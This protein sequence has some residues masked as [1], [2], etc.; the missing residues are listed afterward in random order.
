[1]TVYHNRLS[2][3]WCWAEEGSE[4]E[5]VRLTD[6]VQSMGLT[7]KRVSIIIA[8][9]LLLSGTLAAAATVKETAGG[10]YRQGLSVLK[11]GA[12][13]KSVNLITKAIELTPAEYRYYNDRGVIY[14]R[15]GKLER[16]LEDYTK[17]LQIKPDYTN[18]LNNRGVVYIQQGHYARAIGDFD[19]A[20]LHGGLE[21]KILTNR[22]LAYLKQGNTERAVE[23]FRKAISYR[24]LDYRAFLYLGEALAKTGK[25]AK[26][27]KMYQL[28]VG[29]VKDRKTVRI[30]EQRI[31]KVDADRKAASQTSPKRKLKRAAPLPVSVTQPAGRLKQSETLPGPSR[32][33]SV[34]RSD[35]PKVPDA[36]LSAMTLSSLDK[37]SR[38]R[39]VDGFSRVSREI[40]QQGIKFRE[41]SEPRKAVV[42]FQDA[43]QLARREK[44]VQ[45]VAWCLLEIGRVHSATGEYFEALP[46]LKNAMKRFLKTK[47][48][49]EAILTLVELARASRA[50]GLK[51][52]APVFENRAR[53]MAQSAGYVAINGEIGSSPGTKPRAAHR[54]NRAK[55]PVDK[56]RKADISRTPS[57]KVAAPTPLSR[58]GRGPYLWGKRSTT[59]ASGEPKSPLP[60]PKAVPPKPKPV[61]ASAQQPGRVSFNIGGKQPATK[62]TTVEEQLLILKKLRKNSDEAGMIDVLE[63]LCELYEKGSDPANALHCVDAVIGFR[64]KLGRTDKMSR[65]LHKRGLLREKLG[66]QT[67]ALEDF[68][69]AAAYATAE[70]NIA[71]ADTS[72]ANAKS[73]A[74]KLGLNPENTLA[75]FQSLWN[76]RRNKQNHAETRALHSIAGVFRDSGKHQPAMNYLERT[77]ASLLLEKVDILTKMGKDQEAE[78][79]RTESLRTL[80]RLDYSRYLETLKRKDEPAIARRR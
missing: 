28:A 29:L 11:K 71:Q 32:Q 15:M 7:M 61:T 21:A 65:W 10:Y 22:G 30:L 35:K 47:S 2:I 26:A 17:A 56:A 50:A 20:L 60:R 46:Y 53:D 80:K 45:G 12:F 64:E 14:K 8:A 73:V 6:R 72:Q 74:R 19:Q 57:A 59:S 58:V 3:T 49:D 25:T 62:P 51:Q 52:D 31:R 48:N 18:A 39:A 70:G 23:D 36:G 69:H 75:A 55:P 13:E 16:A 66:R 38:K 24:P 40:Y 67:E 44:N 41:N 43:L 68:S 54:I 37:W 78:K 42:R 77:S 5:I 1:M 9:L 34:D 63:K 33:A 27:L 4:S 79:T 76:A